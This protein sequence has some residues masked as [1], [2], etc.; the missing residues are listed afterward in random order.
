MSG[1]MRIFIYQKGALYTVECAK[2]GATLYTHEWTND[3]HNNRRDAMQD[4]TLC[5]D[6]CGGNADPETFS[7]MPGKYYAGRYSAPGF[8]DCT[9]WS[10][11]RNKRALA[12]ELRDMYG[13]DSQ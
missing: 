10:Y 6:D 13:E 7:Q 2:C 8:L 9:E 3:D 12:K 11:G 1:F 4:G 5:C